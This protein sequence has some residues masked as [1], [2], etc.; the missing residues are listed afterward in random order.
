MASLGGLYSPGMNHTRNPSED[1]EEDVD[2]EICSRHL[3]V[4][5]MMS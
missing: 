1:P 3:S 5:P 2:A 4:D